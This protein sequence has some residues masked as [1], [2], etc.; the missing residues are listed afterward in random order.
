MDKEKFKID[1]SDIVTNG[2]IAAAYVVITV[3][4]API[5]FNAIQ[6][7]IAEVL[8]FFCFFNRKYSIGLILGCLI[9]NI[10][11]PLGLMDMGFGTL[12][13]ILA[14]IGI[15]FF[16]KYLIMAIIWPVLFNAFI[17]GFELSLIG[18][19][20]WFSVGMVAVGELAVMLVGYVFFM[21]NK[22]NKKLFT[23]LK[24][25]RNLDFRF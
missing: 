10:P 1:Q 7:R 2:L 25:N 23:A 8:M 16:S 11:S 4:A 13:T 17:V 18:E 5:S 12:A 24:F 6:F 21:L 3:I 20:F 15:M 9:S 22:K 19:P 14:C